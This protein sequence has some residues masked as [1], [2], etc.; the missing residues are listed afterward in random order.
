VLQGWGGKKDPELWPLVQRENVLLITSDVDFSDVRKF[1]PGTHGGIV[2][3]RPR[4]ES[5]PQFVKLLEWLLEMENLE[6]LVGKVSV[7]S[8]GRIRIRT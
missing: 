3:L 6:T 8:F 7:V 4:R 1:P 5:V 2:V